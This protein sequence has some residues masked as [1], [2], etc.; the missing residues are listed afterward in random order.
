[1]SLDYNLSNNQT[2]FRA[3]RRNLLRKRGFFIE[4]FV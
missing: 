1:M 4:N 2:P 3:Q